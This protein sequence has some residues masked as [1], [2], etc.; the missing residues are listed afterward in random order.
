MCILLVRIADIVDNICDAVHAVIHLLRRAPYGFGAVLRLGRL[1]GFYDVAVGVVIVLGDRIL[2][3]G[4]RRRHGEQTS[5]VIVGVACDIALEIALGQ[6]SAETVVGYCARIAVGV[7]L[8][9]HI[10]RVVVG[11]SHERRITVIHADGIADIVIGILCNY[12]ADILFDGFAVFIGVGFGDDARRM[13]IAVYRLRDKRGTVVYRVIIGICF[14]VEQCIIAVVNGLFGDA[15][16]HIVGIVRRTRCGAVAVGRFGDEIAVC[17]IE[18]LD[19]EI[20]RCVYDRFELSERVVVIYDRL[21]SARCDRG[22][23]VEAVICIRNH[24]AVGCGDRGHSAAAVIGRRGAV[25]VCIRCGERSSH[26]V[27]GIRHGEIHGYAVVAGYVF[28][29]IGC[30]IC[31]TISILCYDSVVKIYIGIC[32][33]GQH[34]ALRIVGVGSLCGGRAVYLGDG[35]KDAFAVCGEGVFHPHGGRSILL[36]LHG[37]RE[38]VGRVVGIRCAIFGVIRVALALR[39]ERCEGVTV[40]IVRGQRGRGDC[41]VAVGGGNGLARQIIGVVFGSDLLIQF[42]VYRGLL[43]DAVMAAIKGVGDRLGSR[44]AVFDHGRRIFIVFSYDI[45]NVADTIAAVINILQVFRNNFIAVV[46]RYVSFRD[47]IGCKIIAITK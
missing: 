26:R 12:A 27:V 28:H 29:R 23:V 33:F 19:R 30:K 9:Q 39:G 8:G 32:C 38:L 10:A 41:A 11:V 4:Q 3:F 21:A 5:R 18:I 25:S 24:A 15:V 14:A 13:G 17:I 44:G 6:L 40:L 47:R 16:E 37:Q 1:H 22:S 46:C 34:S 43:F 42:V 31:S 7:G 35:G 20:A 36:V 45:R 2:C